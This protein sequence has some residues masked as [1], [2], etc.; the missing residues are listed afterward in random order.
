MSSSPQQP[1][2]PMMLNYRKIWN[3]KG[4]QMSITGKTKTSTAIL[5]EWEGSKYEGKR[6]DHLLTSSNYK[7]SC[8]QMHIYLLCFLKYEQERLW[9]SNNFAISLYKELKQDFIQ[10]PFNLLTKRVKRLTEIS[11]SNKTRTKLCTKWKG[12]KGVVAFCTHQW[13]SFLPRGQTTNKISY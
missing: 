6:R 5:G 4:Y 2:Q 13:P 8:S 10:F 11:T 9:G 3:W 7:H 1:K 12:R